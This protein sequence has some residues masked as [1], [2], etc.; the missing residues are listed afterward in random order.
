MR[1]SCYLIG[2]DIKFSIVV[3]NIVGFL[4]MKLAS[5][6]C[7]VAKNFALAPTFLRNLCTSD[8]DVILRQ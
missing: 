3:P 1:I 5:Y 2:H 7:P 6:H 4:S 8:F